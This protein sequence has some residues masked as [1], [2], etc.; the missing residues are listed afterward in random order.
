MKSRQTAAERFWSKVQVG[1]ESEC[2]PWTGAIGHTGH[3]KFKDRSYHTV[4][5]HRYAYEQRNGSP[6]GYVVRHTCD[7]P[8]CCNPAHLVLGE[9]IDNVADRVR[10]N[11]SAN[12]ERNGRAKLNRQ[13]VEVIRQRRA[14][15]ETLAA[16]GKVYGID[17]STVRNVAIGRNWK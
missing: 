14:N 12:G 9:H 7:N 8:A 13:Q 15:G 1:S 5:A 11:R 17:P 6:A 16:I 2:W 4:N 3:G 10:R